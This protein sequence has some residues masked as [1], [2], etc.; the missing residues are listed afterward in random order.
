MAWRDLFE[1]ALADR[2]L[3]Y[4]LL[5]EAGERYRHYVNLSLAFAGLLI[6]L[7]AL[8][9]R[10]WQA[11]AIAA[12]GSLLSLL[13]A[14]QWRRNLSRVERMVSRDPSMSLLERIKRLDTDALV[15]YL[16]VALLLA[17]GL[18]L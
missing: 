9:E 2:E 10:P 6:A 16:L 14:E 8:A 5:G 18:M 7:R 3:R 1:K 15:Y 17:I 4:A 11:E 12:L 13:K